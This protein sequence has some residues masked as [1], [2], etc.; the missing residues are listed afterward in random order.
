[1]QRWFPVANLTQY[2]YARVYDF[3]APEKFNETLINAYNL[4]VLSVCHVCGSYQ[5]PYCPA[6]SGSNLIT[7]SF[8]QLIVFMSIIILIRFENIN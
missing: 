2:I 6:Y 5:C 4:H 8:L 1:M 7:P 3:Y